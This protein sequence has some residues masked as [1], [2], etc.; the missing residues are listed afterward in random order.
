M[1]CG[2]YDSNHTGE[3][4]GHW[5]EDKLEKWK[6]LEKTTVTVSDTA[7]NMVKMFEFLPSHIVHNGCLNHVLQLV[8]NDEILEK[9]EVKNIVFS[10][11]AFTNYASISTLLS[12]AVRS[13]QE[14]MGWSDTELKALVQDVKTR[15]N[16]TYDMLDRFV[17]LQ[18]PIKK[19]L[20]MGEWKD[21][22][23]VRSGNHAGKPVKFNNNDWKV[24]ERVV[25]LL[26]PFKE[27]T[28]KLSAASACISQS[29]PTITSLLH[30][31]KPANNTTD[32]GVKDLKRRLAANLIE[33]LDYT[34]ES[35]I[36]ALATLLDPRYAS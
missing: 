14:E 18:E 32:L 20:E 3:N 5:L 1:S 7:A 12:A 8:V 11:R 28:I 10:V 34:E 2:P 31:L 33:R 9:P 21:K 16:S 23:M 24:M 29:I 35:D 19:V 26:G 25:K 15:W 4:L 27:A 36:H 30:T 13:K 6:V 17:A 22:I